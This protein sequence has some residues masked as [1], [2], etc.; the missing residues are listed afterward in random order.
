[1]AKPGFLKQ[2]KNQPAAVEVSVP[3]KPASVEVK[4]TEP[5]A[6]RDPTRHIVIKLQRLTAQD[7]KKHK[8]RSS[9]HHLTAAKKLK[10]TVVETPAPVVE[11]VAPVPEKLPKN[12]DLNHT[13]KDILAKEPVC[14]ICNEKEENIVDHYVSYHCSENYASRFSFD[15][16]IN[17]TPAEVDPILDA[18]GKRRI[19]YECFV[20][21][22]SITSSLVGVIYHISSHTG[23]FSFRCDVCDLEKPFKKDI[24]KHIEDSKQAAKKKK[25]IKKKTET[26]DCKD[27][28]PIHYYRYPEN[29][30]ELKGYYC[31]FCYFFQIN[32]AN[33]IKHVKDQHDRVYNREDCVDEKLILKFKQEGSSD[34][35]KDEGG[36]E[37]M[38]IDETCEST[39]ISVCSEVPPI[40]ETILPDITVKAEVIDLEASP[41]II[42]VPI[43]PAN[44]QPPTKIEDDLLMN[45]PDKENHLI[46]KNT[47]INSKII[48]IFALYKCMDDG[49]YFATNL[50][51]E[52]TKHIESKQKPNTLFTCSYCIKGVKGQFAKLLTEHVRSTHGF[53]RYQCNECFYRSNQLS[54]V[55]VH[56]RSAHLLKG[57]LDVIDCLNALPEEMVKLLH[58][59]DKKSMLQMCKCVVCPPPLMKVSTEEMEKHIFQS[60]HVVSR[61]KMFDNFYCL[62]C[63]YSCKEKYDMKQHMSSDHSSHYLKVAR[64]ID[65]VKKG[66]ESVS[67]FLHLH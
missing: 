25:G 15:E 6:V 5:K 28:K 14:R 61:E 39:T 26:S 62:Y 29:D 9:E 12:T 59:N 16:I 65:S 7:I 54:N 50:A 56:K 64:V 34:E 45:L 32:K 52:F 49:C 13:F 2:L 20:C 55:L 66:G 35:E 22:Q 36:M 11:P 46:P 37:N 23:E 8:R 53:C 3:E 67:I 41:E 24:Q 21:N 44:N 27:G 30:N 42:D 31:K 33:I 63:K 19:K 51:D 43:N 47:I 1:M 48:R 40:I 17:L 60:H 18:K 4:S 57:N 58:S 10:P 38:D